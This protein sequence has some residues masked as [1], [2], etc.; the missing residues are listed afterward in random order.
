[1]KANFVP[2]LERVE[3]KLI[4]KPGDSLDAITSPKLEEKVDGMLSDDISTVILD[5][6]STE[7]ISSFG[8]RL[9]LKLLLKMQERGDTLKL[10]HVSEMIQHL[11]K[12][13]GLSEQ[14]H[15]EEE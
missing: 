8:L 15:V 10:I 13:T 12:I 9:I 2:V 1:M 5:L 4:I 7:Y 11:F 6:E 3:D 14:L